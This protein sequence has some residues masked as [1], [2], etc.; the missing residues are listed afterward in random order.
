MQ[1]PL[2][3]R[4]QTLVPGG[5]GEARAGT[6]PPG[7]TACS[8]LAGQ[9]SSITHRFA[10]GAPSLIAR[11]GGWQGCDRTA[12]RRKAFRALEFGRV[13]PR[14]PRVWARCVC[15]RLRREGNVLDRSGSC[16]VVRERSS[17]FGL[18]D[19]RPMVLARASASTLSRDQV[20]RAEHLVDIVPP[21][22]ARIPFTSYPKRASSMRRRCQFTPS[23]SLQYPFFVTLA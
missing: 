9:S 14:Y 20:C 21:V 13:G 5:A 15:V 12:L 1:T 11:M 4:G 3:A 8:P 2:I 6:L 7:W 17:F 23:R 16:C 18:A 19:L 10:C 22:Q